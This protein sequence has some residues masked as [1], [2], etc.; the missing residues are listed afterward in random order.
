MRKFCNF[1]KMFGRITHLLD[2]EIRK[3][4]VRGLYGK[5]SFML[6]SGT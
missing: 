1:V 3:V 4:F 5:E 2:P 6:H